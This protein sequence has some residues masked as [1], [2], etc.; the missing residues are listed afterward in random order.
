VKVLVDLEVASEGLPPLGC[1]LDASTN[2]LS[3][4]PSSLYCTV[5]CCGVVSGCGAAAF[6]RGCGGGFLLV[7]L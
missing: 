6:W 4:S 1:G 2:P 5:C 7:L 3:P